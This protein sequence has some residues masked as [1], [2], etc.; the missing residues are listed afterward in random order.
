M[1]S[2]SPV[3]SLTRLAL[4]GFGTHIGDFDNRHLL[5]IAFS[6]WSPFLGAVM[7][8]FGPNL[9]GCQWLSVSIFATVLWIACTRFLGLY[10]WYPLTSRP[11]SR[12]T[13]FLPPYFSTT[14]GDSWPGYGPVSF[15]FASSVRL[16]SPSYWSSVS[17]SPAAVWFTF[18]RLIGSRFARYVVTLPRP[19]YTTFGFVC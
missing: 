17:L 11:I 16:W 2:F 18:R 13:R 10:S 14:L 1:G 7:D 8:F 19:G 5:D 6:T 3:A 4:G 15:R 12:V 9:C